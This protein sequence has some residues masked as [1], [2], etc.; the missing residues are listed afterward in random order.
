MCNSMFEDETFRCKQLCSSDS[1]Y[2]GGGRYVS[3]MAPV[4]A[5]KVGLQG[6]DCGSPSHAERHYVHLYDAKIPSVS[7]AVT[8]LS[9][10]T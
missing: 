1:S 5:L 7:V 2:L 3:T 10:I 4:P 6:K 9:T 8:P